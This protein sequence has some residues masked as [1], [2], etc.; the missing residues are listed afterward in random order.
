[1]G[2]IAELFFKQVKEKPDKTAIW[3]DGEEMTYG[4]LSS[5]VCR[6]AA[7]LKSRGVERND[8]IGIPMNNSIESAALML[9]SAAIGAGLAPIN[10]TLPEEAIKTAFEA[11]RVKHIIAR[12]SFWKKFTF[13]GSTGLRLCLD[14]EAEG[15]DTFDSVLS[16]EDRIPQM[17]GITGD[18]TWILTMTSGSTGVPKPIELTQNNKLKRIEAHIRLYDITEND[19][20]L[21]ATPLYHS[22]AERLVM[23]PLTIGAESI[24]LPRFTANLWLKCASEQRVTFTIA[25]SAQLGQIAQLLSSPFAPDITGFRSI[26]SSSAL[27]EPHVRT[28]LIKKLKCDFH[29][30]YGTSETSTATSINFREAE[31]KQQSVGQA[32]PEADIKVIN[33]EGEGLPSSEIGEIA[34]KTGLIFNGYYGQRELTDNAFTQD[35]YFRTGDLGR[36]DEDGYLYFCGRKKELIITGGINVYPY[37]VEQAVSQAEGVKEC[38]AFS[39][40]DD[41]LGE[42]VALAVVKEEA[43]EISER[44]I[45]LY[46]AKRLADF[47]QPHYVFFLDTLPRN[48]MGKL[49]RNKIFETVRAQE[50]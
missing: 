11:G 24:L 17:D 28:E 36:L 16:S 40:P 29:E 31:S 38:A 15:C 46:C 22:L 39:Y 33:D 13:N 6:Y 8:I 48:P 3:C 7:Y 35:G 45:K 14:G 23:L 37:D 41:R 19:R 44:S 30:M 26:V 21:A 25:V 9:A 10:P 42:V 18:E 47:Q 5:L 34:I 49:V 4:E 27:L 1:M 32:I 2:S 20:V 50:A 12:R 43:S